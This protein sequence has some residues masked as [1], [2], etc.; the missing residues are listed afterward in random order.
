MQALP[1]KKKSK[2]RELVYT[3]FGGKKPDISGLF[4]D[5]DAE[6]TKRQREYAVSRMYLKY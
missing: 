6:N 1:F 5:P 4:E 2:W 3:C